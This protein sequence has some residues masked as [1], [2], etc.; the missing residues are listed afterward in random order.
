MVHAFKFC[1]MDDDFNEHKHYFLIATIDG[2]V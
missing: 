1:V 2:R